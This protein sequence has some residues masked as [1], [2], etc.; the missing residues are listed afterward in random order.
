MPSSLESTLPHDLLAV[1]R[2]IFTGISGRR[3]RAGHT[4][5]SHAFHDPLLER[6]DDVVLA[7]R[8]TDRAVAEPNQSLATRRPNMELSTSVTRSPVHVPT[9][10]GDLLGVRADRTAVRSR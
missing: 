4:Q 9:C 8:S 6:P 5:R 10:V 2:A 1:E 7:L 3:N